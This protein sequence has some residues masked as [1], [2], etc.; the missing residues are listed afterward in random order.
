MEGAVKP[1]YYIH[2]NKKQLVGAV[3]AKYSVEKNSKNNDKFNVK[4]INLENH[5]ALHGRHGQKFLREGHWLAWNNNDLQSFTPVRYLPPELMNFQSRCVVVDPDVFALPGTDVWDLFSRDMKGKAILCRRIY[6]NKNRK[7]YWASSVMLMDNAKLKYWNWARDV[8]EMF[9]GKRDYRDWISLDLEPQDTIG[10]LEEAWNAFDKLEP[11]MK[12]IHNTGRNTQPWKAGLP[13]DF[14]PKKPQ[15][16]KPPVLGFIPRE[17]Y[18]RFAARLKG[19][20]YAPQG[21]YVKH[22]DEKQERYFFGLLRECLDKGIVSE[23]FLRSE[24][25]HN[26]IRH[27]SLEMLAKVKSEPAVAA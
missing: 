4:I 18:D 26:H 9:T 25:Q 8:D 7:P 12:L 15:A 17:R 27:D 14:F 11:G 21:F 5:P 19:Q 22:P 1:T 6:P 20:V 2:S 23:K 16:P 24:M 10:E 13:I 3:V